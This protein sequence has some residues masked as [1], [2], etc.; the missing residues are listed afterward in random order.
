MHRKKEYTELLFYISY[1]YQYKNITR[2]IAK[3]KLQRAL[4]PF[5]NI[6]KKTTLWH[7]EFNS[8]C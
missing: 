8:M 6:D 3:Y 7:T 5:M 4:L 2:V 1:T